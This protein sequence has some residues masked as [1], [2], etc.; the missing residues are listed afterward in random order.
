MLFKKVSE[1]ENHTINVSL[2]Q[3]LSI[4]GIL[5]ITTKYFVSSREFSA[6]H[7]FQIGARSFSTH[8]AN[9]NVSFPEYGERDEMMQLSQ[10]LLPRRKQPFSFS[11]PATLSEF[12]RTPFFRSL[13]TYVRAR[14]S[15]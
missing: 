4:C 1:Y 2:L 7:E 6:T 10:R 13:H 14:D 11:F 15:S 9:R 5:G 12:C 3:K 8:S